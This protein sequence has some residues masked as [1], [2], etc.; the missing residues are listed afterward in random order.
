MTDRVTPY[1]VGRT[2]TIEVTVF[3]DGAVIDRVL[4]ESEDEAAEVVERWS[5]QD[6]VQCQIDD[7]SVHHRAGDVLE[8]SESELR[9]DGR[10]G[11]PSG[12]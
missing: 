2:P 11:E 9:D 4:C 5:E 3:R 1:D 8:P 12:A 6:G 7:L 10:A